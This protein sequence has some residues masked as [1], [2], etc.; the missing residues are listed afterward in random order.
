[1]S[2]ETENTELNEDKAL[3]IGGVSNSFSKDFKYTLQSKDGKIL[4]QSVV[5]FGSKKQPFPNNWKEDGFAQISLQDYK[6]KFVNE[7][8][9]IVISEDL[10]FDI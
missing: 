9:D 1:M 4:L 3:H 8:F 5:T 2:K 6:E 10:D 7:N